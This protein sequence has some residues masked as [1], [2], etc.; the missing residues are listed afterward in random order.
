M[1]AAAIGVNGSARS[2]WVATGEERALLHTHRTPSAP[3]RAAS[4]FT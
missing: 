3:P 4:I 2:T 1:E